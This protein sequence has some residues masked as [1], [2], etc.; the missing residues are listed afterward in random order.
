MLLWRST[1][2]CVVSSGP[3]SGS[4]HIQLLCHCRLSLRHGHSQLNHLFSILTNA[5][6]GM[7]RYIGDGWVVGSALN[8]NAL[9]P[10]V[11]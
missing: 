4:L 5:W 8:P 1:L 9:N 10:L 3:S 11:A 2:D 7:S 6:M